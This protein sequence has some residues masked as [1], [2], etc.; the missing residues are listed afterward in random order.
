[1]FSAAISE[2]RASSFAEITTTCNFGVIFN[3]VVRATTVR[4]ILVVAIIN[5]WLLRRIDVNNVFLNGALTE[6]IYMEQTHG[7]N[8][9]KFVYR[10]NKALYGLRQAPRAWFHTLRQ[11]LVHQRFCASKVNVSLFVRTFTKTSLFLMV[12]VNDIIVTD[13]SS[14]EVDQVVQHLNKKFSL[15][16][17][18][19]SSFFS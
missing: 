5:R 15:K 10:L 7:V 1:M 9:E 16:D 19:K 18:G 4:T 6:E 17:L 14:K 2:I 11:H 8:W 12:Y 3:L 13:N